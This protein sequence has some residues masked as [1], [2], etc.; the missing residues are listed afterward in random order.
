MTL[1]VVFDT[2]VFVQAAA[3]RRGPAARCLE[4]A[5]GDEFDLY[6]SPETLAELRDVLF[7]PDLRKRFL[8]ITD[9]EANE[10][11]SEIENLVVVIENVP[12]L[13]H[14][15]R[16]P[17]DERYINLALAANA[18][19]LVSRDNDLL[20]L[21]DDDAFRT[22]YPA[23]TILDPVAFLQALPNDPTPTN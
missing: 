11:L 17:E 23:L 15:D 12:E 2:V 5:F 21:M 14:Y 7:R 3:N 16:D 4:R 1:R 13:F 8:R 19:L 6:M 9:E 22:A 10:F 20:D 18:K